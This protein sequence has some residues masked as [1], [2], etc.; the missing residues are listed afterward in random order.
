MKVTRGFSFLV[1]G[2]LSVGCD[3]G[4]SN[5]SWSEFSR[6]MVGDGVDQPAQVAA[7]LRSIELTERQPPKAWDAKG[8]WPGR[9][10]GYANALFSSLGNDTGAKLL[11]RSLKGQLGC[12]E[13]TESPGCRFAPDGAILPAAAELWEA[14]AT[15]GLKADATAAVPVPKHDVSLQSSDG[16]KPLVGKDYQVAGTHVT[17]SGH[18]RLLL[19]SPSGPLTICGTT[20][21]GVECTVVP[22]DFP[23]LAQQSV[24]LLAD[25]QAILSGLTEQGRKAY[26]VSDGKEVGFRGG[27]IAA[28]DGVV[29]EQGEAGKGYLALLMSKGKVKAEASFDPKLA[30]N[31]QPLGVS[32]FVTWLEGT[33]PDVKWQLHTVARNKLTQAAS[34]SGDFSGYLHACTAGNTPGVAIWGRAEG[35][36]DAQR[37][38]GGDTSVHATFLRDGKWSAPVSGKMPFT[39]K[40]TAHRCSDGQIELFWSGGKADE[41]SVGRLICSADGCKEATSSWSSF[42][43]GRWLAVGAAGDQMV[44]LWTTKYGETRLRVG[45]PAN[46]A[47][48]KETVVFEGPERG[49]PVFRNTQNFV[50]RHGTYMLLT[51]EAPT[52]VR[53]SES[54]EVTTVSP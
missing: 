30:S 16:W 19:K 10:E 21:S 9:C 6:C 14:A 53:I 7:R 13:E 52:L 1:L 3:R 48:A 5:K 49:G 32:N 12:D 17:S 20:S 2:A 25:D 40:L 43:I 24:K 27:E 41:L 26:A 54:G 28:R 36:R 51:H 23:K 18:V 39:R 44:A 8:Q 46:F 50:T 31:G 22:Q 29:V 45:D 34:F 4:D 11:K 47:E 15:A 38:S 42:E 33:P 37:S 35:E